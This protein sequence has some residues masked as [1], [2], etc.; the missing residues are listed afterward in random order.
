MIDPPGWGKD[1]LSRFLEVAHYNNKAA[2]VNLKPVLDHL[3]GVCDLFDQACSALTNMQTFFAQHFLIDAFSCYLAG[4]RLATSGQIR[5]T[6]MVLRGCLESSLYGLHIA[7]DEHTAG[8]T[9]IN[10][11]VDEVTLK[12]MKNEF[13]VANVQKTLASVDHET[14]EVGAML[15]QRTID[16]GGHPNPYSILTITSQKEE[17]DKTTYSQDV[18]SRD[19][20]ATRL[21]LKTTAETGLCALHVFRNVWP[22]RF[23]ILGITERLKELR[24]PKW[25]IAYKVPL[26]ISERDSSLPEGG[27]E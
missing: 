5:P 3:A 27:L 14:A 20:P 19:C 2:S 15:Y 12:A 8:V 18:L 11:H 6:Y 16:Y 23:D 17:A 10:R 22:Q 26:T 7:Q 24:D 9:W 21:C 25:F 13:S 4:V 1:Y